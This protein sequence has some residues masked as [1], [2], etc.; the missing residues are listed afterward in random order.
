[1][2]DSL[3][4]VENEPTAADR[5][6]ADTP[7]QHR[8]PVSGDD[9]L[10]GELASCR[11]E[12]DRLAELLIDAERRLGEIPEL[13]LRVADLELELAASQRDV[14]RAREEA[15]QLDQMLMYGRRMLRF[16]RPLIKPLRDARRRLRR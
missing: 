11:Q 14:A 10:A 13:Q 8:A 15:Q 3:S 4:L 5:D 7:R 2:P 12:R 9:G 16:V 1:V 6:R